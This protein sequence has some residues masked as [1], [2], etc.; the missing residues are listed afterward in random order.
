MARGLFVHTS[1]RL[2]ELAEALATV[3]QRDPLPPLAD[4]T[5][6]VPSQGLARWLKQQLAERFGI[7]AGLSL[8]FPGAF[9]RLLGAPARGT[10]PDP[11]DPDVLPFRIWRLLADAGLAASFG[12]AVAYVADDPDDRKR[13]QLCT[14]IAGVLD[15]YQLY[16]PELL[17]RWAGG[18][19]S[20]ELGT[21][22]GW[23][24]RLWRALL[25]DAGLEA[26][27]PRSATRRRRAAGP[28]GSLP[29]AEPQQEA[30]AA[31]SAHRVTLLQQQLADPATAT[32]LLPPRLCVFGA[33][34]LP[35]AFVR[36][37]A[38]ASAHVPVHVFVPQPSSAGA[39]EGSGNALLRRFGAQAHAFAEELADAAQLAAGTGFHHFHLAAMAGRDEGAEPRSLLACLQRDVAAGR[40]VAAF[41]LRADDDSLRV[42]DCHSPQREL[43]VVRDQILAAFD[44]DATLQPHDV[45]VLVPDID[46]Y[47][48]F[49][50]AVFGPVA[51]HLPFQVADKSPASELPLC[52]SVFAVLQLARERL[53]VHDVLRLLDEPSVQRRFRI[54][55]GDLPWLR[56]RCE[57][58]GIRW[59]LDG[60]SRERT[61]RVPAFDE[62]AWLPGLDRLLL[63]V[64]TGPCDDLVL[65]ALP[66]A[67]ATASREELLVRFVH[68]A[69]TLFAQLDG[70]TRPQ[71]LPVWADRVDALVAAMHEPGGA[72]DDAALEH[73]RDATARLRRLVEQASF[74][75]PVHPIVLQDWLRL[76]L[77]QGSGARGFLAGAVTVAALLPM[78]A[79]PVRCLFVCG[80]DDASFPR[81]DHPVAFDLI[82]AHAV[83]GDRSARSDDRQM[84]LDVLMAARERLH[85]TFVGRSQ[86]DDSECAPS[87]VLN[88]LLDQIDR[89]CTP[90]RSCE[91]AR[92]AVLVRHALQPWSKTYRS[93]CDARLFTFTRADLEVSSGPV[94]EAPWFTTPVSPPAPLAAAELSVQTLSEFWWHPCRYFL[95]HVARIRLPK[96]DDRDDST[97]PFAVGGLDRWRL[98]D[99]L[100]RR[101]LR[102]EPPRR[103]PAA[104]MRATGLLPVG[105][106]GEAAFIDV[107]DETQRFLAELRGQGNLQRRAVAVT[108]DGITVRGD[109][110]GVGPNALV[111]GRLA[112]IKPKDRL[113]AWLH[114]VLAAV[115]RADGA[116]AW[117]DASRVITR[118]KTL[119]LR[120]LSPDDAREQL[121][122]LVNGCRRGITEPLPFFEWS[123]HEFGK[124]I[125]DGKDV[126][127]A[128]RAA[129]AKWAPLAPDTWDGGDS[130]EPDIHL[131]WRGRDPF[132]G[133]QF[134][135]L[136]SALW[137]AVYGSTGD[138]A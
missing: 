83:R 12:P 89:T 46:R 44:A 72:D 130:E 63:G 94:A 105:G 25:H 107:D 49:A 43:E 103:M 92:D 114:H 128:L 2:E 115:A 54:F 53:Q 67:D 28:G 15:D 91:R 6:V 59:G 24:A 17:P 66:V 35:P 133:E 48:P 138:G 88:E 73:L 123:S 40:D 55:A 10:A 119:V 23:Q 21:H 127:A 82:A 78:R 69:H 71:P 19:D 137:G 20:Q 58:A 113:R 116:A 61:C 77:R 22:A 108:V 50:H 4:D 129:R 118:N 79:V 75:A 39:G 47:A 11:F 14:R 90:P 125:H 85:L 18:D 112:N 80:L 95:R 84:F 122:L 60:A 121:A 74:S 131:C 41:A 3:L 117:P 110:P 70:L 16:R 76:S 134:A 135:E 27:A 120:P 8:P 32:A 106:L 109:V 45:L 57:A 52:A 56:Q 9:L 81:R 62:N 93:G 13:F 64:A 87:V 124:R 29:F 37:L 102:G 42:H 98:Q 126:D 104:H 31:G 68:F 26:P 111:Y 30:P 136:A 97:E 65:G 34:T 100:V 99:E 96:D 1:T 132:A 101:E 33:S 5:I 86:K 36:L 51:E 7:A 38:A